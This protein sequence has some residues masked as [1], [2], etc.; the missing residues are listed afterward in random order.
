MSRT[1]TFALQNVADFKRQRMEILLGDL[2]L[3][4]GDDADVVDPCRLD[5]VDDPA[6]HRLAQYLVHR[7][8]NIGFHSFSFAAGE[9]NGTFI[10]HE[11]TSQIIIMKTGSHRQGCANNRNIG[12][13]ERIE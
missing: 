4:A 10:V 9:D 11:L 3:V 12:S 8:G 13:F 5:G 2:R 7:L 6:E 1:E